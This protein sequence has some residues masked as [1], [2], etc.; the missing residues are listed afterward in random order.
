M[1]RDERVIRIKDLTSGETLSENIPMASGDLEWANDNETLFYV[2]QQEG[3]LIPY[4]VY[5]HALGEDHESDVLVYEE[6]DSTFYVGMEKSRTDEQIVI[7][8]TQTLSDEYR[9]IRADDP[10]GEPTLFLGREVGHEYDVEYVGEDAFIRTNWEAENFRLMTVKLEDSADRSLWREIVPHRNDTYLEDFQVFEN[11]IALEERSGGLMKLRI[12]N[13][14]SGESSYVPAD[15]EAY[16]PAID[17]NPSVTTNV[18]RYTYES[19][20]TPDSVFEVNMDTGERTLLKQDEV[21]GYEPARFATRRLHAEA[22]DGARIPVTLLHREDIEPDG[23]H[24]LYVLGYGSY[25]IS[26]DPG[27]NEERISLVERGFVF[28]LAH[29]RG[30]QELGRQ[31]YLDGKLL[32]KRNTFY[33]FIDVTRYLI[34]EG[35]ADP[36]RIVGSGRSAGGL[37]AGAVANMAPDLFTA[38]R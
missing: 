35:W 27:F 29:I 26:Y 31:W 22:R 38:P 7:A 3:T 18:L 33:D 8:S 30:G 21:I 28:A 14:A 34:D 19:L 11:H 23:S 13:R 15:E 6:A 24:P 9:S 16:V 4:R 32:N 36:Q 37:L 25:G 10:T 1:G 5:R 20:A 2:R 17:E 12:L